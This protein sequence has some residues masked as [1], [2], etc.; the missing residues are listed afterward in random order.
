M[1]MLRLSRRVEY[2]LLA[3]QYLARRRGTASVREIAQVYGLSAEF[4]AKVLQQLCR[5]G[6]LSAQHGVHG[7]YMLL[8]HPTMVTIGS[9]IDAVESPW[10]GLV[11]CRSDARQCSLFEHCTIR[12]PLAVL[13]HRLRS[14]LESMT[15]AE[16]VEHAETEQAL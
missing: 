8:Q 12:H 4:L 15:V 6:I 13:E 10:A 2:A 5:A 14:V 3:L 11:E 16:L 9:V 7:G 1:S